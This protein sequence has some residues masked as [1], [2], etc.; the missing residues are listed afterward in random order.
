M[1]E[2]VVTGIRATDFTSFA[3]SEVHACGTEAGA[4]LSST[5]R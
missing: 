2:T 5:D 1:R 4:M 3:Q